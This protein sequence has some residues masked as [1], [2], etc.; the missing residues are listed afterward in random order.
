MIYRKEAAAMQIHSA[1][2]LRTPCQIGDWYEREPGP[3]PHSADRVIPA[4]RT[5]RTGER[6]ADH[7]QEGEV[8]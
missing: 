5:A 4:P 1:R 6:D 3:Q 8:T 2:R 7:E